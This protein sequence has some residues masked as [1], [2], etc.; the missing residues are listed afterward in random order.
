LQQFRATSAKHIIKRCKKKKRASDTGVCVYEWS[1][2]R[3][4]VWEEARA[5]LRR[6]VGER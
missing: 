5:R 6:S 1:A 3:A 4:W 2:A